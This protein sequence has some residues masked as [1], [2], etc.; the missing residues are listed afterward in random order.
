[1]RVALLSN[2][3]ADV[4]A[5]LLRKDHCVWL[6]PGYDGWMQTALEPPEDLRAFAPEVIGLI[7]DGRFGVFSA[8]DRARAVAALQAA[9]PGVPVLAPD[10]ARLAADWGE[11]FYDERMWQLARMPFSLAALRTLAE[12][13]VLR[14]ALAVDLDGTLWDGVVGEDGP[15]AVVPRTD[16]QR[17]LLDLRRR[18]VPLVVLSKN[19]PSDLEGVWERPDMLVKEGD[20]AACVIGWEPKAEGLARL[21]AELNLGTDAFVFVDDNP[22]ERAEM[23]ARLPEVAVADFPPQLDVFF[24]PRHL[25]AEDR[26]RE[27]D[28]RAQA[29][30]RRFAQG[31]S[32]AD[33]LKGLELWADIHEM[34]SDEIARVAQLSQRANQFNVV[35]HRR[36]EAEVA[37]L[38]GTDRIIL[39]VVAGDRFG[40]QGLVGFVVAEVRDARAE[41]TDFTLSCR[42]MNRTLEMA[43][44][45]RL[46]AEL[47]ARGVTELRAR[48]EPTGRNEPVRGLFPKL[49]FSAVGDDRFVKRPDGAAPLRHFYR[50][51]GENV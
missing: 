38:R 43:L 10:L 17:A 45:A 34:S 46:E 35:P 21:A 14:K 30:R 12:L 44:E 19:N 26:G 22:A 5:D 3:T 24:P 29:E 18:G 6:A 9:F 37:A 32:V 20:F 41:I 23:R 1:M 16:F 11:R 28:Y 49:G 13:F 40:E 2:V 42:A 36:T 31:L 7:L 8:A 4:L 15:A 27:A 50:M 47:R 25:T 39:T 33:Y 48:Y 51:K